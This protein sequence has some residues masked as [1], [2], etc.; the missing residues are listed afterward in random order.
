MTDLSGNGG[1]TGNGSGATP[2]SG[3][4]AAPGQ[5]PSG[6]LSGEQSPAS[7]PDPVD[8]AREFVEAVVW[9]DHTKVWESF[10]LE[11]RTAVLK[12]ASKRGMDEDLSDRLRDGTA[13]ESEHNEF[14][15]DLVTGLRADMAGNDLDSLTFELD[16]E[17][18]DPGRA[19]VVVNVPIPPPMGGYLPAASVELADEGG[20]WKIVRLLPQAT[21]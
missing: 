11:A 20:E 12:L 10:G 15:A 8:V 2:P 17:P 16:T 6:P 9:G 14:L 1:V 4:P 13:S 21:K 7:A 5:G 19:R 18:Q 3:E